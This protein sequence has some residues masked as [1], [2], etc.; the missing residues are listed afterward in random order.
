MAI[1]KYLRVG[2]TME[3]KPN[4]NRWLK[5]PS[6]GDN[7]ANMSGLVL[8]SEDGSDFWLW[9]SDAGGLYTKSAE[10]TH[11]TTSATQLSGGDVT[12]AANITD[13]CLM[14]GAGGAKGIELTTIT[15][16]DTSYDL[17]LPDGGD[18]I[19]QEEIQFVG[20]TGENKVVL[21]DNLASALDITEAATSYLKF[22]T[23][24]S[25]EKVVFGKLFEAPTASKIGNLT[26]GDGSIVDSG[27]SI[28]FT[29][30]DLRTGG[31]VF[32]DADDAE[33]QFGDAATDAWIKF[34][35]THLVLYDTNTGGT[36]KTLEDLMTGT[37][38]NPTVWGDLG[39]GEGKFD[40]TNA[41]DE[42]AGTWVFANTSASDIDISSAVADG[43]SIHIVA[44][45]LTTGNV[46][47]VDADSIGAAGSLM[48]LE[49]TQADHHN[50]GFFLSCHDHSANVFSV[51]EFG[52]TIIKGVDG[53]TAA[54]TFTKGDI[55]L[56][57]GVIDADVDSAHGH[58]I[59]TSQAGSATY[60]LVTMISSSTSHDQPLLKLDSASNTDI[61]TLEI[62]N[63]GQGY[64]ISIND[65]K[66]DGNGLEILMVTGST[67]NGIFI[68]ANTGS[69][70]GGSGA[71][72]MIHLHQSG[73][74]LHAATSAIFV[75]FDGVPAASGLGY[76]LNIDDDS[77]AIGSTYAVS[78]NS[79][80]NNIMKL[81][82]QA[83][84]SI[85]LTILAKTNASVPMIFLDGDSNDWLGADNIGMLTIDNDIAMNAGASLLVLDYTG[86]GAED[87][88]GTCFRALDTGGTG[89]AGTSYAAEIAST[90]NNA[91][92]ISTG[93]I[94]KTALTLTPH[95]A[96]TAAA[97]IVDGDTGGWVGTTN[98]GMVHLMYDAELAQATA[99]ALLIDVGTTAP[100][101][102]AE[103]YCLRVA[104]TSLV[105][106]SNNSYAAYIDAT[107]NHGMAIETRAVAATNLTLLGAEAQIVPLMIIEGSTG[108]GWDGADDIGMLELRSDSVLVANGATMLRVESS[109]TQKAGSEGA[110]ARFENTGSAQA[111]AVM[112]EIIAADETE[113]AINVGAGIS[114]FEAAGICTAFG[115]GTDLDGTP[116]AAQF[117]TEFSATALTRPGFIGVAEDTGSAVNY[118][119]VSDGTTWHYIALTAAS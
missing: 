39:V 100:L 12:A 95:T 26:L 1:I 116:T 43:E 58:N 65:T 19:L 109:A 22:T 86:T 52:A 81:E 97:V 50:D 61:N 11:E 42:V 59:A 90:K 111:D 10:P 98:T 113:Y 9:F 60:P 7:D 5:I 24:N 70:V 103:G 66:V 87:S 119:V 101:D 57:D 56:T 82:T 14:R 104:D 96:G 73:T 38:L 99:S 31:D 93:A 36:G 105:G 15:V 8:Q 63:D 47:H 67:K 4:G 114:N 34:D 20:A 41:V 25:G 83:T 45:D 13:N 3:L 64:G 44:N 54:L 102:A 74:L 78:V 79:L 68:D 27:D 28:D 23:T 49:I 84:G 91:L 55:K 18:L 85:P 77:S 108:T 35:G 88:E 53:G 2:D 51:G 6:H 30:C 16:A 46:I 21:T 62:V 106:T 115:G 89:A 33:L 76:C 110:L 92:Q 17:T 75:N 48:L 80:T 94:S 69:Y 32:L 117:T 37:Q 29:D 118:L 71:E 107:A 72:G 112:V 40:W